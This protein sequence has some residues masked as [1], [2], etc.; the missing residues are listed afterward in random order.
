M[1]ES[2]IFEFINISSLIPGNYALLLYF[3]TSKFIILIM[4]MILFLEHFPKI[5]TGPRLS[6]VIKNKRIGFNCEFEAEKNEERARFEVTWYE[7]TPLKK[8]NKTHILKG[9]ERNVTLQN[10]SP[11]GETSLF[12][13][14]ASVSY[15]Q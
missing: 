5:K 4:A 12:T 11:F 6:L 1:D 7:G 8:I 10:D 13:F 3:D 15:N 9:F 14:G 2:R